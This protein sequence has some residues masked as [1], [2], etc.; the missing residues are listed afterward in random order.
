MPG[1][2]EALSSSALAFTA[3]TVLSALA[4]GASMMANTGGGI[5]V[6]QAGDGV[7]FGAQFDA[8]HIAQMHHRAVGRWS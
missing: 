4:P 7:G 1:G 5:A 3:S 8:R 2:S 6:E